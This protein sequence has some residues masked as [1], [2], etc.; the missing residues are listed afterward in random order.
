V[1]DLET[2][3]VSRHFAHAL[4]LAGEFDEQ[5]SAVLGLL[6]GRGRAVARSRTDAAQG[7]LPVRYHVDVEET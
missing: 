7:G 2:S 4:S 1:L 6:R 5:A 3:A